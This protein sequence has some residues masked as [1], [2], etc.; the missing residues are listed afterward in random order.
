MQLTDK[1]RNEFFH[2][3]LE[4]GKSHIL[5]PDITRY[6]TEIGE[7]CKPFMES[8]ECECFL[9]DSVKKIEQQVTLAISLLT[10][11]ELITATEEDSI[12][13]NAEV[14][15]I[16]FDRVN[17]LM[18]ALQFLIAPY[19]EEIAK[20]AIQ[21]LDAI[22]EKI[23]GWLEEGDFSPLRFVVFNESRRYYLEQ[24]PEEEKYRFPWYELYSD[25][26]ENTLEIIIENFDTFLSG[27]WGKLTRE[28]PGEHLGEI[29]R[30]LKREKQLFSQ[31]KI[32]ASLHKKLLA[33]VTKPS[34]LKL[35]RL[36]DNAALDYSLP[37]RVKK[38]GAV[39]V[40]IKL[41]KDAKIASEIDKIDW[42]F[43]VAFCGPSLDDQ[44]R[45]SLLDK[46]EKTIKEIDV[47]QITRNKNILETLK[48]WF[49]GKCKDSQLVGISFDK[50]IKMMEEK[51]ANMPVMAIDESPEK[52]WN[53]ITELQERKICIQESM[54]EK[55]NHF[56][57]Y[58]RQKWQIFKSIIGEPSPIYGVLSKDASA[59]SV[60]QPPGE[61]ILNNN[62]I[63]L[64]L[65]QN[66]EGL[67]PILS[68]P[69]KAL[70]CD[71]QKDYEKVWEHL[72]DT[73]DNYWC[74]CAVT[75]DN[76]LEI[77]SVQSI[78]RRIFTRV[79]GGKYK[80]AIICISPEKAL[81]AEFIRE[82][83]AM[84]S[85]GKGQLQDSFITKIIIL[86]ISLE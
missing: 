28:I 64:S 32:E 37:Q 52:L 45:L 77:F 81:L 26:S 69:E 85:E 21:E 61:L 39:R 7:N 34:S 20:K 58:I 35:W 51:A 2:D 49:E 27:K 83:P 71:A 53:A 4:W 12:W 70:N 10:N 38:T 56:T 9:S 75:K 1:N 60:K 72:G 42:A 13:H 82:L 30:E 84:I 76:K 16:A 40:G 11:I 86:I 80:K 46:V 22:F 31:L 43:L 74:G 55:I 47:T 59:M 14:S 73:I 36:G 41:I 44:Q 15:F 24:I 79:Q 8:N 67:Y 68:S 5:S 57:E 25:Y 50:W 54:E 65:K 6:M 66:P 17:Y 29:V 48:L 62:P 78:E 18:E 19:K 23:V 33:A 63:C 3:I